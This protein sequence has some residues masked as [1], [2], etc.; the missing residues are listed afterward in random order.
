MTRRGQST[1]RCAIMIPPCPRG[2]P[3]ACLACMLG[4]LSH[5]AT[6]TLAWHAFLAAKQALAAHA[7]WDGSSLSTSVHIHR[8]HPLHHSIT[9]SLHHRHTHVPACPPNGKYP[10]FLSSR[11]LI[12]CSTFRLVQ[13]RTSSYESKKV[14]GRLPDVLDVKASTMKV[15]NV[16]SVVLSVSTLSLGNAVRHSGTRHP[17]SELHR[18]HGQ[19]QI[20]S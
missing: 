15:I 4:T 5:L 3:Y 12:D 8:H 17:V 18:R 13:T 11:F 1:S 16:T 7:R 9:P 19:I 20:Q 6:R 2:H 10:L 14:N